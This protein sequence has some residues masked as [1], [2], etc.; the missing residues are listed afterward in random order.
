M[1]QDDLN[2]ICAYFDEALERKFR[3]LVAMLRPDEDEMSERQAYKEFGKGKVM[4]WVALGL[5]TPI[6]AGKHERSRKIYYRSQLM[7]L[8]GGLM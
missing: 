6:R 8:N 7:E 5:I 4:N 3:K 1:G 2:K